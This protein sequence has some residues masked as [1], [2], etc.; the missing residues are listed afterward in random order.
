MRCCCVSESAKGAVQYGAMRCSDGAVRRGEAA[1]LLHCA[2]QVGQA[3]GAT[4]CR[5]VAEN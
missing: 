2:C 1:V 5:C 4:V 3:G